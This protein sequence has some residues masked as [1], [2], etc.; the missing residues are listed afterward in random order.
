MPHHARTQSMK[1]IPRMVNSKR[2]R[3]LAERH[4]FTWLAAERPRS[5]SGT[6]RTFVFLLLGLMLA[7]PFHGA[8]AGTRRAL[9][10]GI[11]AYRP[12][13]EPEKEAARKLGIPESSRG[14]SAFSPLDGPV[15]DAVS[16]Q[17]VLIHRFGFQEDDVR[18][19]PDAEATRQAILDGLRRYF[20]DE[21]RDGD[22]LLFYFAGHGSQ[23]RNS[24]S[25][26]PDKRDET[27][28]PWDA[29]VGVSDI[30]DKE[31]ARLLNEALDKHKVT[32]TVIVD[33]C[34]SGSIARGLGGRINARYVPED[35]RDAND[36]Y[37]AIPPEERGALIFSAAQYNEIAEEVWDNHLGSKIS[38]G[39]F[40]LALLDTLNQ[41][42]PNAPVREIFRFTRL[43]LHTL[44]T[45]QEPVMAGTRERFSKGLFGN[46]TDV[47]GI[48]TLL[49]QEITTDGKVILD[50]GYSLGLEPGAELKSAGAATVRPVRLRVSKV[51]GLTRS[52][53]EPL[54]QSS[55][56]ASVHRLDAFEIDRW[57]FPP[58]TKLSVWVPRANLSRAALVRA[59]EEFSKLRQRHGITWID[60]PTERTPSYVVAWTG[61]SWQL[62]TPSTTIDLGNKP[63]V[64]TV[65]AN[66][67]AP[68][69]IF[70]Y[71]PPAAELQE[72]LSLGPE[73]KNNA[74]AI[75]ST[76]DNTKYWLVGRIH[77]GSTEYAWLQP[78]VTQQNVE[79]NRMALPARSDWLRLSSDDPAPVAAKL[80]D[81]LFAIGRIVNWMTLQSPPS[82]K[83][84]PY[85]LA[86]RDEKRHEWISAS[87]LENTGGAVT[88]NLSRVRT[89]VVKG[90]QRLHMVL[91]SDQ[92]SLTGYQQAR[93][94]YIFGIDSFGKC[95][96]LFPEAT[97]DERSRM[98]TEDADGKYPL[99]VPVGVINVTK[100][101]GI[102][103]YITLTTARPISDLTVFD[104]DP[105]RTRESRPLDNDPLTRL[106]RRNSS[107]FRGETDA[108]IA[109]WSIDRLQVLSVA[110]ML[111]P[112]RMPAK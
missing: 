55:D 110:P 13:T 18:L 28:V 21:A 56:L 98:P 7:I 16:M 80:T 74:I 49:V 85:R 30:R 62:Q 22:V 101:W 1:S 63:S 88:E 93:K 37:H 33:S 50:A 71:M 25:Y 108:T 84:F 107:L 40:T 8:R 82:T 102:D 75:A 10:V 70:V 78:H 39:A 59:A 64:A 23:V 66:L 91:T 87:G 35:T 72:G 42:A 92:E 20:V 76:P 26:K 3:L 2:S 14:D 19:L 17:Q 4:L 73:S 15:N 100:P 9:V 86:L 90:G 95:G 5:H 58:E 41:T 38:H 52:V 68:A 44:G 11:A 60:D 36:D 65:A 24:A 34:H 105:V 81:N 112:K 106:L 27:I 47:S 69:S 103:T 48:P 89:P 104:C 99:D 67:N 54:D 53:A 109:D 45:M 77:N 83:P 32:I 57:A 29:N 12:A 6:T 111:K 46:L 51:D 79:G 94:V 96:L 97:D 61:E 43:T 31:I